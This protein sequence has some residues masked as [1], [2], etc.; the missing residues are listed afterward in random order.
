MYAL[1]ER[2][3][4][5]R[6]EQRRGR[7][8]RNAFALATLPLTVAAVW[9]AGQIGALFAIMAIV[10]AVLAAFAQERIVARRA[11]LARLEKYKT[12]QRNVK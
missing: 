11:E 7:A 8:G 1:N 2:I 5:L 3:A 6:D 12:P 4:A 9:V 10:A